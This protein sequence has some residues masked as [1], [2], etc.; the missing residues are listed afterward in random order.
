MS[1]YHVSMMQPA[2]C[3]L[4]VL[5]LS[6]QQA[7][8][9]APASAAPLGDAEAPVWTSI[10]PPG[11]A[12]IESLAFD[13]QQPKIAFAALFNAGIARST[14][15]GLTWR[16]SNAGLTDPNVSGLLVHPRQSS[17]VYG[18]NESNEL[19]RSLDGGLTWSELPVPGSL[20]GAF[21]PAP[22]DSS[23]VYAGSA[24]GLFVSHDSGSHWR[25]VGSAGLPRFFTVTALAV[26][27]GNPRLV[28]AG[29]RSSSD[30]GFF[31]SADAG[32]TWERRLRGVPDKL[33]GDPRRFGFVYLLKSGIVQR[34]RD[35]GV[36][37]ESY[38]PA[39]GALGLVFDSRH[40]ETAY[41]ESFAESSVQRPAPLYRT[42]D[43]GGHWQPLDAGLPNDL[44]STAL[45]ATPAG[46]LL[47]SADLL[48][49][50]YR[51]TNGGASWSLADSAAAGLINTS[52]TAV[53]FGAA[54]TLFASTGFPAAGLS[55]TRDGGIAWTQV[56]KVQGITALAVSP[57]NPEIAYAS[58]T[59]PPGVAPPVVFRTSDGGDTWA[60]LPYPQ[61]AA[62]PYQGM[63]VVD[64]AVDPADSEIVYLASQVGGIGAAGGQGI[65]LSNDGGQ[66]WSRAALPPLDYTGLAASPGQAGTIWAIAGSAAYKSTD[67]GLSWTQRLAGT[68]GALLRAAA[69]SPSNPDVVWAVGDNVTFRSGDGGATWRQLPGLVRPPFE[70]FELISH[71]LAVDPL[72]PFTLYVAWAGGVSRRSLGTGWED[73]DAGL[74][75]RD[76]LSIAFDPADP[77]HLVVGID[78]AGVY[79]THLAPS[80]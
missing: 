54:G 6:A 75:N 62:D 77:T 72:D 64:L 45:A 71:P 66:T 12:L 42:T 32:Q 23:L 41:I 24:A 43:D 47:F 7:A 73:F 57:S 80:P 10:G 31:A 4:V 14:D 3:L 49:A 27:A 30:F 69:V 44:S 76:A 79:E 1:W 16:G 2:K 78:G 70:G 40:P 60:P 51:S 55:R 65:Y 56:L 25:R 21:A 11:P 9:P 48:G 67:H 20:F 34:S 74:L 8:L 26:D 63:E 50:F 13:Q 35:Q 37:W 22:T 59:L 58:S 28:Y 15:G 36:T 68:A 46:T 33:Y 18:S 53:A 39:G 29:I 38:F 61:P 17:L 52:V 5:A 19:V